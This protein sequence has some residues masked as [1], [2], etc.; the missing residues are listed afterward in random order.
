MKIKSAATL[1]AAA[2][3]V[4][5][6]MAQ[7]QSSDKTEKP[8]AK[9]AA[10]KP[11]ASK[12]ASSKAVKS[13]KTAKAVKHAAKKKPEV[14][15]SRTNL[16]T[17]AVNA[18]AGI[19]AAEA[20]LTPAE[21]AIAERVQVGKIPCEL[22]A[23]VTLTADAKNPGYFDMQGKNFSYRM[24]PV[25]TSTGAIRLEDQKAGAV[26]LQL[27]NK[28]MLMNQK[29]G[30]RLADECA[31]PA[32]LEVAQNLKLNPPASILDAPPSVPGK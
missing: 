5:S 14:S 21:L 28:S 29:Q 18:A 11:A 32:Q 16:K 22:G 8:A 10:A 17:T 15:A 4:F 26:W 12:A 20:A 30:I 9:S 19:S 6:P 25:T 31:S 3:F 1:A 24:F 23:S 13:T 27:A 2:L 7:A